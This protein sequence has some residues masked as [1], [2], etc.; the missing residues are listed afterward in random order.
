MSPIA[1]RVSQASFSFSARAL[2]HPGNR[3]A[4][5]DA[6]A[7]VGASM[8]QVDDKRRR[9]RLRREPSIMSSEDVDAGAGG[10][11]HA[12]LQRVLFEE[13]CSI[14]RDEIADPRLSEIRFD[15][16]SLSMDHAN[17]RV[18]FVVPPDRLND[19][20]YVQKAERALEQVAGFFRARLAESLDLKRVP[21]LRFTWH[22]GGV[23]VAER[24]SETTAVERTEEDDP[25]S[26]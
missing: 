20:A 25:W 18:A 22:R 1:Q 19:R 8:R 10:H 23:A 24:E 4:S 17:A 6:H 16:V 21:Q 2:V 3:Q 15:H 14:L 12:R 13:L 26:V 11:R 7:P 5:T 9:P